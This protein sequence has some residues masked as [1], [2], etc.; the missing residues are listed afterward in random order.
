ME[1]PDESIRRVLSLHGDESWRDDLERL[2]R[3]DTTLTRQTAGEAAIKALQRL[4]I[5]LG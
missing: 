3:G 1:L 4:L 2:Q 5:F